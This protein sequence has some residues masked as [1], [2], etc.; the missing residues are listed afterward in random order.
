MLTV[1]IIS[2]FLLL[3]PIFNKKTIW[4]TS[5]TSISFI[6][7]ISI[8]K[9]PINSPA[10]C[11]TNPFLSLDFISTPLIILT[12]W[13]SI[14][15]ISARFFIK[16]NNNSP[17]LFLILILI[18]NIT[19]I[20]SFISSNIFLFYLFFEATLIPTFFIILGWGYQPERLQA[21]FYLIIYTVVA[22]LPLLIS[23]ILISNINTSRFIFKPIIHAP[24]NINII[25]IWWFIT[26]IA[27]I[28][29]T[30]L[31][32]FHLW[33]PK[34]HVEA[35]VAG[36]II[37]AGLLL[38]L[39]TYGLLRFANLFQ[40]CNKALTPMISSIALWGAVITSI[41]CIRQSDIKSLIAYSSV[42]HIGILTA[43]IISNS[44][45]G[46]EGALII[47]IAHGLCSSSIFTLANIQ[48][49]TTSTRNIFL[50]KGILR[51]FPVISLLWFLASSANIAAPPS[52]N[53]IAEISL[54]PAILSLRGPLFIV[55]AFTTFLAAAYSLTL[56]TTTQH[57]QPSNFS[58]PLNLF[59]P[60]N[61][62]NIIL[63]LTPL[64]LLCLKIDLVRSWII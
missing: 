16:F 37:L 50:T 24:I 8:F 21:R 57:G 28:A 18:L 33:L 26:I 62:I 49:E 39:G 12:L 32:S 55:I 4:S 31:Y 52:L 53:L 43:G 48:Y 47:I 30:P 44:T 60:R 38:K 13:I 35:P 56:Y 61:Y 41:I 23:I 40:L 54:I 20:L 22:S 25:S 6:F 29:K 58:N 2:L 17:A 14:L 5:L 1:L 59:S 45:W 63:H 46:W 34:A 64:I 10:I 19:L 42:G 27:F 9:A 7:L 36:S 15:I 3:L 11:V 51:F